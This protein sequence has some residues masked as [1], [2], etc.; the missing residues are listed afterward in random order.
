M[1]STKTQ[2]PHY[3]NVFFWAGQTSAVQA[4]PKETFSEWMT[5][6]FH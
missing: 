5:I 2:R 1:T 4:S 6:T 3:K